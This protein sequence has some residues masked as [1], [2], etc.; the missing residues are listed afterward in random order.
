MRTKY[1]NLQTIEIESF[2]LIPIGKN[3]PNW[4]KH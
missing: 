2:D 4:Q 1:A 3:Q